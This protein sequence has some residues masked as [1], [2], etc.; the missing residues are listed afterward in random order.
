MKALVLSLFFI[1]FSSSLAEAAPF[2][3][4]PIPRNNSFVSGGPRTFYLNITDSNLNASSVVLYIRAA[5][6]PSWEKFAMQCDN[7][8]LSEWYCNIT[9]PFGI[10]GSDTLELYYFNA[11]DNDGN[12]GNNGTAE[13]PL[14]LTIDKNPPDITY[15]YPRNESWVKG[16]VRIGLT[17]TDV[18]SGVNA[19]TVNYST[20]NSTWKNMTKNTNFYA[21]WNTS[22]FTN[23]QTITLYSKAS[24]MVGNT[25]YSW[26][27]VTVDNEIPQLEILKP[28]QNQT[29][30]GIVRFEMNVSDIYS[31]VDTA[32]AFFSIAG[33]AESMDC[34]GTKNY[35]CTKLF[36][37][38]RISDGSYEINFSISD[39]AG[40]SNASY[41]KVNITNIIPLI[42]ITE[43][44][45]NSYVKNMSLVKAS[46]S[47]PKN[48]EYVMLAIE[49]TGISE[50]KNMS[51]TQ[52]FSLCTY[53]IDTTKFKDGE[54]RITAMAMS[55]D[56]E[57][58]ANSSIKLMF[59]NTKPSL[60]VSYPASPVKG[61]FNI[62]ANV[63]DEFPDEKKV[64]FQSG[65]IS[66]NM[67]CTKDTRKLFCEITFDSKLLKDGSNNL[68]ISAEDLAG[69]SISSSKEIKVDNLAPYFKFLIIEPKSSESSTTFEFRV[70]LG[71]EGSYVKNVSLSIRSLGKT[72]KI[73]LNESAGIWVAKKFVETGGTHKVD[74][75]TEDASNNF[76]S[77][78]D[79]GYFY[80]GPSFCG[81]NICEPSE[82]YCI[83]AV[84]CSKPSCDV[85]EIIDCGSGIPKCVQKTYCG[86]GFCFGEE[87]C[88]SCPQDCGS[89]V[90]FEEK[91]VIQTFKNISK[92]L[93]SKVL[94]FLVGVVALVVLFI[95]FRKLTKPK[96]E[97]PW[98]ETIGRQGEQ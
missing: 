36:D 9:V 83:C 13:N 76:A 95:L 29:L 81:N 20:D 8:T 23:N 2:L 59:D 37:T 94:F 11:S 54:Y 73:V 45:T 48:V 6:E 93:G 43:P 71:D 51:C 66:K 28:Y 86:D 17:V 3:Y 63:T 90:I 14:M 25:R 7:S 92:K 27:N 53:N 60:N 78:N 33:I 65:G 34:T 61:N 96:K 22:I 44:V 75:E 64:V 52:D 18:S 46:L 47:D 10:V 85:N 98:Y 79:V 1:I 88:K 30:S 38:F 19:S 84:D 15:V 74:I 67:S 82:N 32:S 55:K 57:N 77:L 62:S 70:G 31:G 56:R 97:K 26:I 42:R 4:N 12:Y 40:N 68:T 72:E 16:I 69:N 39:N 87:D 49:K 89:C 5:D 41:V 91:G 50:T 24:D 80:I 35:I 58:L 21:D